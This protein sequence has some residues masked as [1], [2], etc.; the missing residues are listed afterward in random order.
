MPRLS[1][2]IAARGASSSDAFGEREAER[3]VLQ[4]ER[5]GQHHRM[6]DAV[7]LQRDRHLFGH[8]VL[9]RAQS[10]PRR[11][12]RRTGSRRGAFGS[13]RGCMHTARHLAPAPFRWPAPPPASPAATSLKRL[14]SLLPRRGLR[15]RHHL[16]RGDLVLGAVG[17]PVGVVGGDHV[18]ARLREVERGVDHARLHALG[19]HRAQHG[20]AGAAV[21]ADPVA[22]LDAALLGVVRMDLQPVLARAT[23][24]LSVRRVC[25]PT[26]YCDRMRP[27]VSSS[28]IL[29][30]RPA[31]RSARTR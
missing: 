13:S 17:R 27:V 3:E 19:D 16:H 12:R 8:P 7:E 20:L 6:R 24:M 25:A 4:V 22:V 14:Y 2:S 1:T 28:G 10:Q 15:H 23:A 26:L 31:R 29:A 5:R 9:P 11:A 30:R 21:D 18:G